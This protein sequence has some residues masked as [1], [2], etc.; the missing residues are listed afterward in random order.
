M[1]LEHSELLSDQALCVQGMSRLLEL[2]PDE[3]KPRFQSF[4]DYA[5]EH[6]EIIERFGRFP[7]RNAMMSRVSTDNERRF[8]G[9]AKTTD[10]VSRHRENL[11]TTAGG[12]NHFGW[13]RRLPPSVHE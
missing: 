4:V 2:A 9:R 3:D 11:F 7:H 1:P 6:K 12:T 8:L 13:I 10:R 5:L